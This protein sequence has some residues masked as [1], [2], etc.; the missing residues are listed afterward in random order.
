MLKRR[1]GLSVSTIL[2][3][4]ND[5]ELKEQKDEGDGTKSVDNIGKIE[6]MK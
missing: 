1:S 5:D 2:N 3:S 6:S 4:I